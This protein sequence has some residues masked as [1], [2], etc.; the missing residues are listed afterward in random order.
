MI[1]ANDASFRAKHV[2]AVITRMNVVN[3]LF[4]IWPHQTLHIVCQDAA[5]AC[6]VKDAILDLRE[7]IIFRNA[8]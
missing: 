3:V 2:G 4:D 6:A 8:P 5:E 1:E 7:E